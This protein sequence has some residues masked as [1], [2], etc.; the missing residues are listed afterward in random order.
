LDS[1]APAS[2]VVHLV[3]SSDFYDEADALTH[4]AARILDG[5]RPPTHE[6][7]HLWVE[8]VLEGEHLAR[9]DLG[10]PDTW[11]KPREW[12]ANRR[13]EQQEERS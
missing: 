13:H 9:I 11:F 3:G 5:P 7:K 6:D 2:S 1:R 8:K 10:Y 4:I 12:A